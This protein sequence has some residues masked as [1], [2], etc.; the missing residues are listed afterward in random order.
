MNTALMILTVILLSLGCIGLVSA[1]DG[2]VDFVSAFS[3]AV[4][5][6][7]P[8]IP[9]GDGGVG[10]STSPDSPESAQGLVNIQLID[11]TTSEVITNAH[12]LV[13]TVNKESDE[14][15]KTLAYVDESGVLELN[16]DQGNWEL[17]LKADLLST[18]GSDYFGQ[19]DIAVVGVV[20]YSINL[21]P[22]G[23]VRGTVLRGE[24]NVVR[25]A[26][27]FIECSGLYGEAADLETDS[28]GSY[29]ANWLPIGMCVV[30]ASSANQVGSQNIDITKG[31]LSETN[32]N[33]EK[34]VSVSNFHYY[35][36]FLM[37][38]VLT[39][40]LLAFL[41]L[42]KKR[43]EQQ[44][45]HPEHE[46]HKHNTSHKHPVK[47]EEKSEENKEE[48]KE[49]N[50]E[51]AKEK[52]PRSPEDTPNSHN[53]RLSDI[54]NTLAPKEK[55][56]VSFLHKEGEVSQAKIIYALTI[57]KTTLVRLLQNLEAKKVVNIKKM[58]K[59]KKIS[60]T[61]WVLEK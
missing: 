47:E 59:V 48:D 44:H 35:L 46:H 10:E 6:E 32:I 17:I 19:K 14:K 45:N 56:V 7:P 43:K 30:K 49:E 51:A 57:P 52:E 58:G 25:G 41:Q 55:D 53:K 33:L 9:L 3:R 29:S 39:T 22:V 24:N 5:I 28:F 13:E 8:V 61:N 50:K 2:G 4:D 12:I 34:E 20:N 42:K 36:A 54:L 23:S 31:G 1:Q 11:T 27:V 16:M 26:K 37:V 38:L 40:I 15:S 18:P 60:L 21:H